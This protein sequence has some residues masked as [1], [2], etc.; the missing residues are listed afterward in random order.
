MKKK[1]DIRIWK[2]Y[3]NIRKE[4]EYSNIRIFVDILNYF[5]SHILLYDTSI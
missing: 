3:S 1:A 5:I 4:C 2:S